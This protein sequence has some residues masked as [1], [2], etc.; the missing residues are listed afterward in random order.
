MNDNCQFK[1]LIK[2]VTAFLV[3]SFLL[4]GVCFANI[5][6]LAT[7]SGNPDIYSDMKKMMNQRLSE[8]KK[9]INKAIKD[10]AENHADSVKGLEDLSG[11]NQKFREGVRLSK[12]EDAVKG[13]EEVLSSSDGRIQVIFVKNSNALPI[14]EGKMV[15][16]HAGTYV[17]AFALESE[18]DTIEGKK[19]IVARLIHEIWA[20]STR[21]KQLYDE[22]V[23]QKNPKTPKDVQK[24]AKI[25]RRKYEQEVNQVVSE[26]EQFGYITSLRLQ[27]VFFN[28]QFENKIDFINRD[29]TY[30]G[31]ETKEFLKPDHVMEL[32]PE[33][34]KTRKMNY[35]SYSISEFISRHGEYF[36]YGDECWSVI[37][38]KPV[39]LPFKEKIYGSGFSP[40]DAYLAVSYEE[41]TKGGEI[42]DVKSRIVIK[43]DGLSKNVERFG[44]FSDS[45]KFIA[46]H[47]QDG[48]VQII[49]MDKR[50]VV[51][52]IFHDK[53]IRIDFSHRDKYA[54]VKLGR[55]VGYESK[56]YDMETDNEIEFSNLHGAS[57]Q[58]ITVSP[59]EKYAELYGAAEKRIICNLE[60]GK[61]YY[62]PYNIE[63][64]SFLS[65]PNSLFILYNN[66]NGDAGI[67][68]FKTNSFKFVA[69]DVSG[70]RYLLLGDA[71]FI[72]YNEARI[73]SED[74]SCVLYYPKTKKMRSL[75][76]KN[77]VE[78]ENFS[79]GR[80]YLSMLETGHDTKNLVYD[81]QT[82]KPVPVRMD[83]N[84]DKPFFSADG[85]TLV[86]F[87]PK[88][89]EI[90]NLA[91]KHNPKPNGVKTKANK[92]P[93]S[94]N[95]KSSVANMIK[96]LRGYTT[97]TTVMT[98][99]NDH[100]K[101]RSNV[102]RMVKLFNE[103][104]VAKLT[105]TNFGNSKMAYSLHPMLKGLTDEQMNAIYDIEIELKGKPVKI[106]ERSTIPSNI[107]P[108][109]QS[110]IIKK[111]QAIIHDENLLLALAV[112]K[113][114]VLW[115]V[116][117]NEL[118]SYQD[119]MS[120][121]I[122]KIN[123]MSKDRA[124][125]ERIKILNREE[126]LTEVLEH[127]AKDSNNTVH[128][129]INDKKSLKNIPE[130]IKIAIFNGEIGDCS[131]IIGMMAVSRA[132]AIEKIS[133]RNHELC[134]LHILLTGEEFEG[135][136]TKTTDP[137]ILAE[138]I[139]FD[140]PA[141]LVVG[142][143]ELPILRENTIFYLKHA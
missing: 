128:V 82:D 41:E 40:K 16:G 58:D 140:L 66:N 46:A 20:R 6:T 91:K 63:S 94:S 65:I 109:V 60:T 45:G 138:A 124:G 116:F 47:Q 143:D 75:E 37:S 55:D 59:D 9:F 127:L 71:I 81:V 69:S 35:Y 120:G 101:D 15:W 112:P 84:K 134:R 119:Q 12:G 118:I 104:G 61:M 56:L 90:Y 64:L 62:L 51:K 77:T 5:D 43:I 87:T 24:A 114:K 105:K 70:F 95:L 44:R 121:L 92:M 53:I 14:F 110:E 137:K 36:V 83:R 89:V 139:T 111:V 49:D 88:T 22:E 3:F 25:A 98:I 122:T 42:I 11:I 50:K 28:L 133:E 38:G 72:K 74:D 96:I 99:V 67:Y 29:F 18:R 26:I 117:Q 103:L 10:Y 132:L 131:Q 129:M 78:N 100:N 23:E 32:D 57:I 73:P 34:I 19:K 21:A 76:T 17:T 2:S 4:N 130:K 108:K 8:H 68:N 39:S 141:I 142:V 79:R 52:N 27:K 33:T 106:L 48:T 7:L 80:R 54:A 125:R 86:V 1:N 135:Q 97:P 113:G 115:H 31:E 30:P 85:N 13:L 136:L 93:P 107:K 126:N 102:Q 123:E